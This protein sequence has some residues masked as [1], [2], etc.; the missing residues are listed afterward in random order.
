MTAGGPRLTIIRWGTVIAS[1]LAHPFLLYLFLPLFGPISNLIVFIAPLTAT[2]LFNLRVGIIFAVIN[3]VNTAMVFIRLGYESTEGRPKAVFSGLVVIA[4]CFAAEKLRLYVAQRK[5]IEEELA[6]A[7]KMEAIGR[8]AG[9]VAHDM[10]NTLNA[11][12]GSVF[13]HR[14]EIAMYG[15]HFRDLDNIA[16]ACDRGAQLTRNL[17]GF[18]RKS[19]YKRQAFSMND[20]AEAVQAILARTADKNIKLDVQLSKDLP[21]MK[22]DRAQMENA[23]MNLCLNALDAM[24]DRGTLSMIVDT[25]ARQ[26]SIAV[27]DTGTGMD[28]T[29]REQVFEP[30]FTTKPEG[31]GTGLGLSMVYGVVHA[32]SGHI[33]LDT[34]IG[35]GTTIILR[36]PRAIADTPDAASHPPPKSTP[37][38]PGDLAGRTVLLIDDEPLVLRSGARMLRTLGC[39]VLSAPGGKEGIELF[40]AHKDSISFVIVDLIM[41]GMDGISTIEALLNLREDT[42]ILLVSGYTRDSERMD[43]LKDRRTQVYFLAKPYHADQL[44][45]AVQELPKP[46]PSEDKETLRQNTSS[47]PA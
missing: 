47:S 18:A 20:V 23:V 3:V 34:A 41:P 29:V 11:I 46:I 14:Q 38:L 12:M 1:A 25:D 42:P 35:K 21:L 37:D 22:G 9:G 4:V 28:D 15:R 13:A 17:L 45:A 32:M 2:M 26:V 5:E 44:I 6:R 33:H 27:S 24:N 36:F 16:A 30:F 10:N 40:E 39:K 31:K 7:K 8:L 19:N 43:S